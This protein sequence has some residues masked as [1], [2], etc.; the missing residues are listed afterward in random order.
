MPLHTKPC[1]RCGEPIRPA[2]ATELRL[3]READPDASPWVHST[4]FWPCDDGA[5]TAAPETT[6]DLLAR[7]ARKPADRS[8][9]GRCLNDPSA[10]DWF[11]NALRSALQRDPADAAA[12]AHLL[13]DL[14]DD[15]CR[16][17]LGMAS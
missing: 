2:T 5:G 1:R 3:R 6:S 14:L 16:Q 17:L 12:D 9:I 11:R 8:P 15:R 4:G 7:M 13:A 10:S